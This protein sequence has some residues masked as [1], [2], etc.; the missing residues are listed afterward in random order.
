MPIVAEAKSGKT[1][2]LPTEGTVQAVLA[3]V[4]D[5]GIVDTVYNGKA[6]KTH[7]VLFRWQLA[8]LDSEGQPKRV[9]ERFTLSLH[10]KAGLRKRVAQMFGKEPPAT[11]DLEKI[12]GTNVNLVIVHAPN[13]KDP[14]K[15]WANIAAVL[16]LPPNAKKLDIV[17]IPI[18]QSE[19]KTSE[20]A[21]TSGPTEQELDQFESEQIPF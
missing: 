2:E 4:R 20:K 10:E 18:S 14:N 13:A 8:E 9:Y 3:E 17:A 7:K 15:P 16:R 21:I 5:L 1:F 19:V 11:L 6:K 12:V